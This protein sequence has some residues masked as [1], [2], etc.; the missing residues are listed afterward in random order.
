MSAVLELSLS[1]PAWAQYRVGL[2]SLVNT[3]TIGNQKAPAVAHRGSSFIVVWASTSQDGSADGVFGQR[4]AADGTPAG[5]EFQVN[6]YTTDF[7]R[8]P[9]VAMSQQGSFVLV[10]QGRKT[11]TLF[12]IFGQRYDSLGVRQGGE[13]EVDDLGSYNGY[14]PSVSIDEAGDFVVVWHGSHVTMAED[15]VFGRRFES[16]GSPAGSRFRI[17]ENN[18]LPTSRAFVAM[19]GNGDLVAVWDGMDPNSTTMDIFGHRYASDGMP[20]DAKNF[21]VNGSSQWD[22]RRPIAGFDSSGGFVVVWDEYGGISYKIEGRRFDS[23]GAPLGSDM[24]L[25]TDPPRDLETSSL[26]VSGPG[27]FVVTWDTSAFGG[28]KDIKG[29]R[30][31]GEGVS[32]G[33][34]ISVNSITAGAQNDSAVAIG[35]EECVVAWEGDDSDG[36]GIFLRRFSFLSPIPA[37]TDTPTQTATA[38][39]TPTW[40]LTSTPTATG[41]HTRTPSS[42]ATITWTVTPTETHTRTA[43]SSRTATPTPTESATPIPTRT[44][45]PTRTPSRTPTPL[46]SGLPTFTPRPTPLPPESVELRIDFV[47]FDEIGLSWNRSL[48]FR[49]T[50]YQLWRWSGLTVGDTGRWR[51]PWPWLTVLCVLL[52]LGL[53]RRSGRRRSGLVVV[54]ATASAGALILSTRSNAEDA[55]GTAKVGTIVQTYGS[56]SLLLPETAQLILEMTDRGKPDGISHVD[57]PL[58]PGTRYMYQVLVLTSDGASSGSNIAEGETLPLPTATPTLTPTATVT[59]SPTATGTSTPCPEP[60]KVLSISNL[61]SP[62]RPSHSWSISDEIVSGR[63][64]TLSVDGQLCWNT[65]AECSVLFGT[66]VGPYGAPVEPGGGVCQNQ[67]IECGQDPAVPGFQRHAMFFYHLDPN[68]THQFVTGP[69]TP[70]LFPIPGLRKNDV[71]FLRVNDG[72]PG[73]NSTYGFGA[74]LTYTYRDC[75]A[76]P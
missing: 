29:K 45:F 72:N 69:Q 8:D 4:F 50:A 17:D 71:V 53:S 57:K 56:S 61:G 48:D 24:S 32:I 22:Q 44:L 75:T 54:L 36:R 15:A 2:E 28:Q 62:S 41:T 49:F 1:G 55:A 59:P 40:T 21:V 37:P 67:P 35:N 47:G 64:V 58:R 43:T 3:Y 25:A 42:T 65:E 38:S 7:Q 23:A 70:F 73:N 20:L 5:P 30:F 11:S 76:G 74:T 63:P 13:F 39:E 33:D 46:P 14:H 34:E 16:S 51:S 60:T 52:T 19:K 10:W 12:P 68:G 9:A 27:D 66:L 18:A 26:G 6:T 31:T